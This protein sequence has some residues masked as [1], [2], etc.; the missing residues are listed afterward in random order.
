MILQKELDLIKHEGIKKGVTDLV[1]EYEDWY[2]TYPPSM[3]GKFH[4]NENTMEKHIIRTVWFSKELSK[5]FDLCSLDND[6]LIAS[7]ILHDIGAAHISK[8][9]K[10]PEGKYY[11]ET[12]WT[13]IGNPE[14][15]PLISGAV[16]RRERFPEADVIS[17][18]V[19]RHMSHWYKKCPQPES[20]LERLLCIADYMASRDEIIL[21]V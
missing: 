6:I 20:L 14:D 1:T 11:P 9:G 12:G 10:H 13:R 5:E 2:K 16:V 17:R 18:C 4:K 8:E 7:A 3:S 15:H 19:E 21:N